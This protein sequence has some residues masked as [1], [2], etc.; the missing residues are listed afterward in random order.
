MK[1]RSHPETLVS[2]LINE[3]EAVLVANAFR[4]RISTGI[5]ITAPRAKGSI[6]MTLSQ[7]NKR[8]RLVTSPARLLFPNTSE[9]QEDVLKMTDTAAAM[10]LLEEARRALE[11]LSGA[12]HSVCCIYHA[13]LRKLQELVEGGAE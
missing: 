10:D 1:C 9:K 11:V 4:L 13:D 3:K 8:R 2:W 12:M 6:S 5:I 7:H